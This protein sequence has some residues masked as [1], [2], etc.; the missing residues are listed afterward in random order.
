MLPLTSSAVRRRDGSP[1]KC[2]ISTILNSTTG[3]MLGLPL[4]SQYNGS[5]ISYKRLKSTALSIFRSRCSFGTRLSIP[6][7]STTSR[8]IFP[9]FSIFL[10]TTS[11]ISYTCEKAQLSLD[12]FD[13]L[14]AGIS[15]SLRIKIQFFPTVLQ[16]LLRKACIKSTPAINAASKAAASSPSPSA[17]RSPAGMSPHAGLPK[18]TPFKAQ[19]SW[20]T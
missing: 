14:K 2:W 8:S 1:Y 18:L 10:T 19:Q 15:S 13:R 16:T 6:T 20:E 3:S 12:F 17:N 11:I 5:T 7:I 9:R 4:S